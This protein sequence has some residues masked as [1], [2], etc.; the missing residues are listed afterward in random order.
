MEVGIMAE[1][2]QLIS[3][4]VNQKAFEEF[5]DMFIDIGEEETSKEHSTH[6]IVHL[7][8]NREQSIQIE[9]SVGK[10]TKN[11]EEVFLSVQFV[12][13]GITSNVVDTALFVTYY[14]EIL[15]I[16]ET[17]EA[18]SEEISLK[19]K[20]IESG[21]ELRSHFKEKVEKIKGMTEEEKESALNKYKALF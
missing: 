5:R 12:E 11:E 18:I 1:I 21:L 13:N 14:N 7:K 6:K 19:L 8:L 10:I 9:L 17:V 4:I 16:Q 2:Y 20:E 15:K 3:P